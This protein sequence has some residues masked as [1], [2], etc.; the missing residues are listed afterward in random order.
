MLYCTK[1]QT[2]CA[3]STRSCPNCRR[4]RGLRP[5]KDG[6]AVFFMKVR[7]FEAAEIEGLFEEKMIRCRIEPVKTGLTGNTFDSDYLP[8]DKNIYV[9]YQDLERANAVMAAEAEDTPSLAVEDDVP[10]GRR[11][12]IETVSIIAFM[13]LV[14]LLLMA[15]Q[16]IADALKNLFM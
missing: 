14:M 2:V 9:E 16:P 15:A 5:I 10:Q 1:C 7:D 3:D 12:L 6:D 4:S 11:L 13:V 8:T